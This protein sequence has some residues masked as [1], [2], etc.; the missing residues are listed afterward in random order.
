MP[1]RT[2]A[3]QARYA[4]HDAWLFSRADQSDISTRSGILRASAADVTVQSS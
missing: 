3:Q 2:S 1:H 4:A